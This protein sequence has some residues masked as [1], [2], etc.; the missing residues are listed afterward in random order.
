M[1]SKKV[2]AW[3]LCFALFALGFCFLAIHAYSVSGLIIALGFGQA[4][5]A[6]TTHDRK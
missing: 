5:I 3:L 2:K 1:L 6:G 4:Y